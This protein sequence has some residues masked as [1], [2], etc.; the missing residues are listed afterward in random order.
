MCQR[1]NVLAQS[2]R[3]ELF[4]LAGFARLIAPAET[5][6]A[7]HL[8]WC[9]DTA[10]SFLIIRCRIGETARSLFVHDSS[11]FTGCGIVSVFCGKDISLNLG[12]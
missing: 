5:D 1:V 11:S 12:C 6:V 7:N 2:W 9:L 8:A 3:N 4:V 10:S